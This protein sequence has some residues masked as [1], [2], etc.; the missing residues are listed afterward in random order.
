MKKATVSLAVLF[1]LTGVTT[2][3]ALTVDYIESYTTSGLTMDGMTVTILDGN[4][5]I[6]SYSWADL[7]GTTGGIDNNDLT[8]TVS[9]ANT[10]W[11][12]AWVLT[13][14]NTDID[15]ITL[16]GSTGNTVFDIFYDEPDTNGDYDEGTTNSSQGA[17][18][19]SSTTG[20][21]A[22]Y[23]DLVAL[24]GASPE[25]DLYSTMT[26]TSFAYDTPYSFT[27]DTDNFNPVPEPSTV[28]LMGVGL[29]GL[30]GCNRR[31]CNKKS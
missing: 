28:M 29:A 1:F 20:I 10:Y 5:V 25:G 14:Y 18:F 24:S 23:S 11:S 8:L 2:A 13:V 30:F 12:D 3:N 16:D 27:A 19:S 4:T 7:Y 15:T 22:S 9:K 21:T 6:N 26:I 31:R 17:I